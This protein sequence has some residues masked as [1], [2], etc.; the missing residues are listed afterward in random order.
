MKTRVT[1]YCDEATRASLVSRFSYCFETPPG[2]SYPPILKAETIEAGAPLEIDGPGGAIDVLPILQHHGDM[3]SL[4]FRFGDI[5]YSPDISGLPLGSDAMLQ[6][7]DLWIIDALRY[8]PHPSHYS[9]AQALEMIAQFK[10]KR[11]ILTHM[12]GDLDYEK[13]RREL[14]ETVEPAYDGMVVEV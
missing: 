6:G 11:A 14:P 13:L 12:T 9:V 3:P 5:A 7:L 10:P 4:G 1:C 8:T 2:S